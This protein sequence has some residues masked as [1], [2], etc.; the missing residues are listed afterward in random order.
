[1]YI[2]DA[3]NDVVIIFIDKT[4]IHVPASRICSGDRTMYAVTR[5]YEFFASSD[6]LGFL[7][8]QISTARKRQAHLKTRGRYNYFRLS[9]GLYT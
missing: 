1:M 7:Q 3:I 9:L 6:A 2:A 5:R 8:P 4:D